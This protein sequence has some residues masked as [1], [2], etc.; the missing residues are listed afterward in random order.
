MNKVLPSG[1]A[2]LEIDGSYGEGGGQLVRTAVALAATTGKAINITNVRVKRDKAGLAPQHLAA[3]RA[4][5]QFCEAQTEGLAIGSR[6]MT[7]TLPWPTTSS[8]LASISPG[9]GAIRR[10]LRA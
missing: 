4:V 7:S 5:A 10:P 2:M 3:L 1:F 6:S 9:P 8:G